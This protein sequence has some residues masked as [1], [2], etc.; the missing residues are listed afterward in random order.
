MLNNTSLLRRRVATDLKLALFLTA[1]ALSGCAGPEKLR[2]TERLTVLENTTL[3]GPDRRDLVA[4]DRLSLIGP[5]DTIS[6]EIFNVPELSREVQVD[7]SGRIT[8]PLIGQI[9]VA[10]TTSAE[11]AQLIK[12]KLAGRYVRNPD[13]TVN[14]KGSV[15]Q[16]VT[17]DGAVD[18]PGLYPVTNQMTLLRAVAS[19]GGLTEFARDDNVVVLRTVGTRQLAGIYNLAAIRRGVYSDPPIYANDLVIV[20]DSP[21]RR[22]FKDVLS[23]A[24]LFVAPIVALIQR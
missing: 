15:S 13:V 11:L 4:P 9:E 17:V 6:I 2:S 19:S 3:P 14:L 8:M 21:A 16:V 22:R 12:T 7:S 5:A 10:G 23:V 24:P 18:K 20:G 1:F